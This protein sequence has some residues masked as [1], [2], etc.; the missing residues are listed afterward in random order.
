MARSPVCLF[1][2]VD[3]GFTLFF[4]TPSHSE[5]GPLSLNCW[6]AALL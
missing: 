4:G 5:A 2:G 1:L 6:K 3:T